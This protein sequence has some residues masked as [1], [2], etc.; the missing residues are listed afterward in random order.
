MKR[1]IFPVVIIVL[2]ALVASGC[3]G[4]KE[5]GGEAVKAESGGDEITVKTDSSEIAVSKDMENSVA[6]PKEYPLEILPIYKDMFIQ[7]ASR[8][9]DG[10]FV[11]IGLSNDSIEDIGAFYDDVLAEA[12]VMMK[13]V[14]EESYMNMGDMDGVT[15]TVTINPSIEELGYETGVNIIVM[16]S[17]NMQGEAGEDSSEGAEAKSEGVDEGGFFVPE[18]LEMPSGYPKS[19]MPIMQEM[20]SELAVVQEAGDRNLLGY[21]TKSEF[22]DVYD[23]YEGIFIDS[24]NFSTLSKGPTTIFMG[25][26]DGV[27]FEVGITENTPETGQD[28]NYN[29]LIQI[30]YN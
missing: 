30:F 3:G 1:H 27:A 16:P 18:G 13:N 2:I 29:T 25:Q 12:A 17:L 11:V 26:I 22:E 7:G 21:M 5:S 15:Y 28:P 20:K 9:D 19:S 6:I 4:P 14:S 10:S 24:D 23:Y 8:N